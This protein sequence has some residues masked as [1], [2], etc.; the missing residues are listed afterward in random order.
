MRRRVYQ[1]CSCNIS[2]AGDINPGIYSQ[3]CTFIDPT[4]GFSGLDLWRRNIRLLVPLLIHPKIELFS[5][6]VADTSTSA[7]ERG[8]FDA[9]KGDVSLVQAQWALSS[10]IKLPWRPKVQIN[11]ETEYSIIQ[12]MQKGDS[13]GQGEEKK[14]LVIRRHVEYWDVSPLEAILQLFSTT[15]L[16]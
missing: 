3:D 13:G 7:V 5:I 4:V 6:E 16:T 9:T 1:R 15:L 12:V 10:I 8:N 2:Q 11:G 14:A